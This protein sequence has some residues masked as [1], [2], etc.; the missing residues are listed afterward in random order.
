MQFQK[1]SFHP[2]PRTPQCKNS[3]FST[4]TPT[5]N[6]NIHRNI[7]TNNIEHKRN[8]SKVT[9]NKQTAPQTPQNSANPQKGTYANV[10]LGRHLYPG[11][12]GEPRDEFRSDLLIIFREFKAARRQRVSTGREIL[13]RSG[14]FRPIRAQGLGWF[15]PAFDCTCWRTDGFVFWVCWCGGVIDS[16]CAVMIL[17]I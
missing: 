7:N 6:T 9:T 16:T 15:R 13:I 2:S 14:K 10:A 4:T 5:K 11:P 12:K 8:N 1:R 3:K 17:D